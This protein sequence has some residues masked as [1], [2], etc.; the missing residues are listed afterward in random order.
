MKLIKLIPAVC[1]AFFFL[2]CQKE[3][4]FEKPATTTSANAVYSLGG[5]NATCAG[6]TLAGTYMNGLKMSA[7]NT[8]TIQA[9]VTKTGAYSIATTTVNGVSF[10]ASGT[11]AA[12]GVQSIAL[13]ATGTPTAE[14]TKTFAVLGDT[15]SCKFD[16]VFAAAAPPAVFTLSGAPG[17]CT[18][19]TINGTY[20]AGTAVG[21]S[22]TVVI[23]VNVT[24][25]GTYNIVTNIVNGLSFAGTGVFTNAGT[26]IPVT[27]T[28]SG[29]PTAAGTTTLKPA[30][31]ANTCS[32]DITVAAAPVGGTAVY[33]CKIDG[34]AM[35]F[36]EG[37]VAGNKDAL[38]GDPELSLEGY[39]NANHEA[40]FQIFISNNDK[41]A[42]AAGTY[43]G[44]HFIPSSPTSLGYRIEIDYTAKNAD[45]STTIWNTASKFQPTDNNPA[46][47]ITVTSVTAT[48]AKGTFSG[49]LTNTLEGSNKT[50]TITEGTFDLPIQ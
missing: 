30:I 16:V 33:S 28:A 5:A 29:T 27:L 12:T 21:A 7:T 35:T 41:S 47:T 50:K 40:Q 44:N 8:A 45:L 6:F 11:F 37:A 17:A 42:V 20:T 1:I 9:N 22:N 25:A 32:F 39:S 14:G 48:R 2:S 31:G 46:F 23:K 19:P 4:S 34:V 13:L 24:T 15:A 26:D 36:I 43:D 18:L 3:L 49:K 38:S 10:S